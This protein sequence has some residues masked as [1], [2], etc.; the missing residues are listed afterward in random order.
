MSSENINFRQ[1]L[2]NMCGKRSG[3]QCTHIF[4]LPIEQLRLT[5]VMHITVINIFK[6]YSIDILKLTF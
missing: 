3:N 5:C 4:P 6:V 2:L 1:N